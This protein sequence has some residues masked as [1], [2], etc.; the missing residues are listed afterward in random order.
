DITEVLSYKPATPGQRRTRFSDNTDTGYVERKRARLAVA[1]AAAS[2]SASGTGAGVAR[3]SRVPPSASAPQQPAGLNKEAVLRALEADDN[4]EGDD[5]K[6]DSDDADASKPS[7]ADSVSGMRLLMLQLEKRAARNA[8]LR[9]KYSDN[10]EKFM[11]SEVEL[12]SALQE[13]HTLPTVPAAYP[14]LCELPVLD[15]LLQLV[16]HENTDISIAVIDLIE[17]MTDTDVLAENPDD[18]EQ[19]IAKLMDAQLVMML[20]QNLDR[21]DETIKEEADGVH[22]SFG[23]IE[24]LCEARPDCLEQMASKQGL[25]A[26]L[27]KRIGKRGFSPNKLYASELLAILLQSSEPNRLLLGELKGVDILLNQLAHYKRQ[28]P[29]DSEER[30]LMENLFNCLCSAL[31]AKANK[32]RFLRGEG[33]Q[34]MNL[35]LREKRVARPSALKVLDYALNGPDGADNA[36]KFVDILGLRTIFPVFMRPPK[37]KKSGFSVQEIEEHLCSILHNLLRHCANSPTHKTRILAK[38]VENDHAKMERLAEL[39][40]KWRDSVKAADRR[41]LAERRQPELWNASTEEELEEEV[42]LRRL[43]MGLF[44]LQLVDLILLQVCAMSPPDAGVV[45]PVRQM[46]NMRSSPL[47]AVHGVVKEHL[48]HSDDAE[49]KARLEPLLAVFKERFGLAE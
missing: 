41:L 27:L 9:V 5:A 22:S 40:F 42:Y 8:E 15:T 29:A 3:S 36:L 39:H 47:P 23:I 19:L 32:D 24:N 46:F 14:V 4:A 37:P 45:R 25:L 44:T 28:D 31:L 18:T 48:A 43:E 16:L 34:L 7:K 38:F 10:P 33:L 1:A 17:E 2:A 11:E 12:H 30:E 20:V 13:L 49:E 26:C 35:I 21:L 6:V